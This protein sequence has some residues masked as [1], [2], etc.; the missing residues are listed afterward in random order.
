MLFRY[1]LAGWSDLRNDDHW[2][3]STS[4][5]TGLFFCPSHFISL[6]QRDLEMSSS[7]SQAWGPRSSKVYSKTGLLWPVCH[8]SLRKTTWGL[9]SILSSSVWFWEIPP[10]QIFC[11]SGATKPGLGFVAG[12]HICLLGQLRPQVH[13]QHFCMEYSQAFMDLTQSK[14]KSSRLDSCFINNVLTL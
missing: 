4:L 8:G 14:I 9:P 13:K 6:I 1:C 5:L 11:S 3:K 7:W 12:W 10:L 2:W